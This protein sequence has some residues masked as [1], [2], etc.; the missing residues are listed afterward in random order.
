LEIRYKKA[1]KE[2]SR[3]G[4]S[5]GWPLNFKKVYKDTIFRQGICHL[6]RDM[7]TYYALK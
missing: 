2:S 7:T 6:C 1:N 4:A 3:Y 5:G